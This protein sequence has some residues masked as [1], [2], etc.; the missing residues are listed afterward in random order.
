LQL[1][2]GATLTLE[3]NVQIRV[4]GFFQINGTMTGV[5]NGFAGA[6]ASGTYNDLT[7][8]T[9]G[10]VGN[11][12]GSDG[13]KLRFGDGAGLGISLTTLPAALT[14]GKFAAFPFLD[15]QVD[16]NDLIGIPS[17]LRGT[18]G[19]EG[20]K[21][22][23]DNPPT[24]NLNGGNG[25]DS[26]AG[27]S[28][29]CK[30]LSFGGAGSIDL[31][32]TDGAAGTASNFFVDGGPITGGGGGGGPGSLLILLDGG[33]ISLPDVSG[34]FSA[35][36]GTTT[37]T[38]VPMRLPYIKQPEAFESPV[39]GWSSPSM[40]S[41][42]NLSNVAHRIQYIPAL[43]T[44]QEDTAKPTAP[45]ALSVVGSIGKFTL[46]ATVDE[47][48]PGE[49]IE[50]YVSST[51]DRTVATRLSLTTSTQAVHSVATGGTRYF[52]IRKR[53]VQPDV[54]LFSDWFPSSATGG[55]SATVPAVG[56]LDMATGAAT[57][58]STLVDDG[59]DD[60]MVLAGVTAI[61]PIYE[62]SA[63]VTPEYKVEV[64]ASFRVSYDE[65]GGS[66]ELYLYAN[67]GFSF[68]FG[69][70]RFTKTTTAAENGALVASFSP[71]TTSTYDFSLH[72]DLVADPGND[73]TFTFEDVSLRV[74]VIKR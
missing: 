20:G 31:S 53:L 17:D 7:Y 68:A 44:P 36:T 32:G 16:G 35:A 74:T 29:V 64:S 50:Y 69:A 58:V 12:R 10:F 66:L 59:P 4:N 67:D 62:I 33:S 47:L 25:G 51:N 19:G 49:R 21:F 34:K 45:T 30:G 9:Q 71:D 2:S 26:G 52:W 24:G 61:G 54:D 23:I 43:Q 72:G 41:D 13:V 48:K 65:A 14:E 63:S 70:G 39:T 3:D 42:L 55:T 40:V 28:I 27:L 8:G 60:N 5:G 6:T 11:T 38:G 37:V 57:T 73:T 56:T 22:F 15:I 1:A 46:T 18:S